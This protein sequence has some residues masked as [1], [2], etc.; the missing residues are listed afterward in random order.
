MNGINRGTQR[1]GTQQAEDLAKL[2]HVTHRGTDHRQL[3]PEDPG[4]IG[5]SAWSAG[6]AAGDEDS[7][8]G[9]TF[10]AGGVNSL[11]DGICTDI[12]TSA[13]RHP[14]NRLREIRLIIKDSLISTEF[15]RAI[16]LGLISTGDDHSAAMP[17][18]DSEQCES[19]TSSDAGNQ[20]RRTMP[21]SGS[22]DQHAPGSQMNQ[23]ECRSLNWIDI[24]D[25][26]DVFNGSDEEFRHGP[27]AMLTDHVSS[28]GRFHIIRKRRRGLG[29]GGIQDDASPQP[30][31][32]DTLPHGIDQAH[33]IRTGNGR[34]LDIET[35]DPTANP[36]IQLVQSRRFGAN[37]KL[38]RSRF[39][40]W[41]GF[42]Q[43]DVGGDGFP[44][45]T[46]L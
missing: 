9:E 40:T 17:P 22:T 45:T 27:G 6:T 13:V 30:A 43:A 12:N 8:S 34:I 5:L 24:T 46:D 7:T 11:P 28:G 39:R 44:L 21:K 4:K 14:A 15:D 16:Q 19:H 37:S 42:I 36:K 26:T 1:S 18:G 38:S 33:A 3:I 32:G 23:T 2:S 41:A 31:V 25:I 10:E 20:H 35:R 29:H